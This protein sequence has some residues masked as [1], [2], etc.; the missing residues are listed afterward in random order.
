MS[1][2][3][4]V[5]LSFHC[6]FDSLSVSLSFLSARRQCLVICLVICKTEAD[7]SAF[8]KCYLKSEEMSWCNQR[9]SQAMTE[10][11]S[12]QRCCDVTLP[13]P[14]KQTRY[15]CSNSR[16][17]SFAEANPRFCVRGANPPR[18]TPCY[19][20]HSCTCIIDYDITIAVIIIAIWFSFHTVTVYIYKENLVFI[21]AST[22][23][24]STFSIWFGLRTVLLCSFCIEKSVV[25]LCCTPYNGRSKGAP[26]TLAP[27]VQI[28]SFSCIF[29]GRNEVG[30]R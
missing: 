20:Y 3:F 28:L 22:P 11:V 13:A 12:W 15:R 5:H 27:L 4:S 25:D 1:V 19:E 21:L 10:V 18:R 7:Q 30:P 24:H 26:G 16:P 29:T 2:C 14:Q 23:W 8:G 9:M 17:I 6:L